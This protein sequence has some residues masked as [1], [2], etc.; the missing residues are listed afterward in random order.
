MP[1]IIVS[2]ITMFIVIIVIIMVIVILIFFQKASYTDDQ[3][4]KVFCN[5]KN[6]L[7]VTFKFSANYPQKLKVAANKETCF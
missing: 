2:M 1:I 3:T 6:K 7:K 5:P 4:Q